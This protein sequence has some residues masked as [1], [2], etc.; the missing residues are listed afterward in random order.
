[1]PNLNNTLVYPTSSVDSFDDYH[2][3]KVADPTVG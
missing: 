3:T 1:M 2:D